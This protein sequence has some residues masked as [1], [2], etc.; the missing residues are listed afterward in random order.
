MRKNK[1]NREGA[2]LA[3]RL[4]ISELKGRNL[5][6]KCV[7]KGIDHTTLQPGQTIASIKPAVT[8][9]AGSWDTPS[10]KKTEPTETVDREN[11]REIVEIDG[12]LINATLSRKQKLALLARAIKATG[13]AALAPIDLVRA[14][15]AHTEL[16][17]DTAEGQIFELHLFLDP[18]APT[19]QQMAESVVST[20]KQ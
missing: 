20:V 6:K 1:I 14:I 16:A 8:I 5:Y 17:G 4:G 13:E 18:T 19:P 7:E 12:A 11:T 3:A 9:T 15:N 2:E 10:Q